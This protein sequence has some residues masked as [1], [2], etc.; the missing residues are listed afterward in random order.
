MKKIFEAELISPDGCRET[1]KVGA[2][3]RTEARR[4]IGNLYRENTPS[5]KNGFY[6]FSQQILK[7]K[8]IYDDEH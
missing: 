3:T 6:S 4:M 1:Y 5:P 2:L 7:W 8:G